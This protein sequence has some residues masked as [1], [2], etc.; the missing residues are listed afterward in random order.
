[1]KVGTGMPMMPAR[2][3]LLVYFW[4]LIQVGMQIVVRKSWI[5]SGV[6]GTNV[7]GAVNIKLITTE[8]LFT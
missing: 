7:D 2:L 5:A 1:M 8:C 4:L 3:G 6:A